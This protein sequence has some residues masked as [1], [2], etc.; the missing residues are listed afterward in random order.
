M[1]E[2]NKFNLGYHIIPGIEYS[3]GGSFGLIFGIG[4]E[5]NFL[6]VTKDI[7]DQPVDKVTQNIVK[8]RFGVT[9]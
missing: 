5:K 4:F 8:F 6:D 2:L 1:N 9:F 7:N 3:L